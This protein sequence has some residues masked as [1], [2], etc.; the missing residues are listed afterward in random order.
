VNSAINAN[1][2][3]VLKELQYPIQKALEDAMLEISND[4]VRD[5]TYDQLYPLE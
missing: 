4:C 5:F 2:K 3:Q 1:F